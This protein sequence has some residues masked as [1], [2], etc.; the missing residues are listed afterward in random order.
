MISIGCGSSQNTLTDRKHT[1][2]LEQIKTNSMND[3]FPAHQA[4]EMAQLHSNII[5]SNIIYS[6][7]CN[8][9]SETPIKDDKDSQA[10]ILKETNSRTT[11][12]SHIRHFNI[13]DEL[14]N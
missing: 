13:L 4:E 9:S 7:E 8:S 6:Q 3:S 1:P 2:S 12:P 11:V 14:W 5:V 10:R